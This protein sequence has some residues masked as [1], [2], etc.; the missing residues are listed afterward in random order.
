MLQNSI[1]P[2]HFC[3]LSSDIRWQPVPAADKLA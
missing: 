1:D 2:R 3:D